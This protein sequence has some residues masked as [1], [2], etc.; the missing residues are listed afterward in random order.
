MADTKFPKGSW[1]LPSLNDKYDMAFQRVG[2][3][4]FNAKGKRC[5]IRGGPTGRKGYTET[6][7]CKAVMVEG[8]STGLIISDTMGA[9]FTFKGSTLC[10]L[11]RKKDVMECGRPRKRK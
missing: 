3:L 6:V 11:G 7:P 2:D 5:K 4:T 1:K 9:L 10:L 8:D